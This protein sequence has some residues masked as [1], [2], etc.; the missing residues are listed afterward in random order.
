V[1][2]TTPQGYFNTPWLTKVS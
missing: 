2:V 1:D